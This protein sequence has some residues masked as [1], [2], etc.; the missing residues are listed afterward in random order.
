MDQLVSIIT[1][2]YNSGKFLYRLLDSILSQDYPFIEMYAVDDGSTDNTKAVIE[3]YIPKFSA[4]GYSLAYLYQKNSGQSAAVNKALKLINGEFLLWPDSDDFYAANNAITRMVEVL[5]SSDNS[6]SM[7]RCL[8]DYVDEV[9]LKPF[10]GMQVANSHKEELFEDCLYGQNGYFFLAGGYMVKTA[11]LDKCIP[12]REI[13]TEKNAGQN[14]QLMLPLLYQYRCLTI[15]EKLYTILCRRESHSRGQYKFY[16]DV[17]DKFKSYENTLIHTLN[18]MAFLP[19]GVKA[20]YINSIRMKYLQIQYETCLKFWKL[21][22]AKELKQKL[23]DDFHYRLSFKNKVDFML[24]GIPAYKVLKGCL[25]K[26]LRK[27]I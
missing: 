3:G 2:C 17:R 1:P 4:K 18:A 20:N 27:A 11:I 7:V 16:K 25:I 12:D 10:T 6:V 22:D 14:W 15:N 26:I 8:P 5:A 13:Y 9:T 21:R 23:K 24:C 19:E